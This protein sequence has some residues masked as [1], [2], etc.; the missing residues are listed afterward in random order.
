MQEDF[1]A[2]TISRSWKFLAVAALAASLSACA[3][4]DWGG[5]PGAKP[6]AAGQTC[7]TIRAGS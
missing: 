6:L 1:V 4:D 5:D 2:S 7:G 3:G